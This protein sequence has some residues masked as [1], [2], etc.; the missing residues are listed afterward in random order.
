MKT[1]VNGCAQCDCTEKHQSGPSV[2]ALVLS[3]FFT[4][5]FCAQILR[6]CPMWMSQC[7]RI[8][9]VVI[10]AP[11][12]W[13]CTQCKCA[14]VGAFFS[15]LLLHQI[16]RVHS[17]WLC[18]W[19]CI[20]WVVMS[21]PKFWECTQCKYASVGAFFLAFYCSTQFLSVHPMWMC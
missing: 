20:L 5:Y 11:T 13:E 6:V 7:W 2:N 18:S 3:H 16:L 17:M 10:S 4:V 8:F 9:W 19:W 21:A 12:F 14:S 1:N 15:F